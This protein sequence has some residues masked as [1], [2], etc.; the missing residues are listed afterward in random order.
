MLDQNFDGNKNIIDIIRV[1]IVF[2]YLRTLVYIVGWV[3]HILFYNLNVW[4]T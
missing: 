1:S 3:E 2:M 4:Y